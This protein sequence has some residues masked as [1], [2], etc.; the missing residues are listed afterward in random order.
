MKM[1]QQAEET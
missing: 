1:K